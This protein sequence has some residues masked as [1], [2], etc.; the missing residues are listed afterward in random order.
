MNSGT[1]KLI[2]RLI[3]SFFFLCSS[4]VIGTWGFMYFANYDIYEAFYMTVI[5]ISTVGYGEIKPLNFEARIFASFFIIYNIFILAYSLSTLGAYIFEGEIRN[6]FSS[7]THSRKIKSMK[8]HIIVCGFGRYG[9]SVCQQLIHNKNSFLVIENS[10][11]K[12]KEAEKLGYTIIEGNA[13]EDK[14]LV[15]AGIRAASKLICCLPQGADN[16]YIT[17]T[18]REINPHI[19]II[20]RAEQETDEKKLYIAGANH[21][22]KPNAVSATIIAKLVQHPEVVGFMQLIMGLSATETTLNAVNFLDLKSEFKNK[23][24]QE[25]NLKQKTGVNVIGLYD[26]IQ[27]QYIVNPEPNTIIHEDL[28]LIVLGNRKQIELLYKIY[29]RTF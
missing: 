15:Q 11:D 21:V 4:L 24:I 29:C 14:I 16:V 7:Y 12:V 10:S 5:T 17:L 19:M 26:K 3:V 23:S 25:L 18:A 9:R 2:V 28:T 27:E 6:I 20:A 13:M 1:K 8:N 22:I